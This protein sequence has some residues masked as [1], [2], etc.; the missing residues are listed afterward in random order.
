MHDEGRRCVSAGDPGPPDRDPRRGVGRAHPQAGPLRGGVS[1]RAVRRPSARPQGRS[2]PAQPD[3]RPRSSPRS[4]SAYLEAGADITTTNTFTATSIGQADYGLEGYAAEMSFEGA[5]LARPACDEATALDPS[6]PRFVAGSIGPLN[7]SLSVSPKVDDPAFR[8][9][10]FDQVV[11]TYAEQIR[12]LVDGGADI[13]LIETIF[14]TLNA[15]AAIAAALDVA[16]DVPRWLSFTA[17]DRSGRNLSGQTVEAFWTS[18]EH[19]S[20]LVVGINCA[21][22]AGQ[23]RPFLEEIANAAP[24]YVACYPNAGLP[25]A[26]GEHDE[27]P[28]VTGTLLRGFA[29]DGLVNIVGGCCGTTPEHIAKIARLV[30]GVPPRAVPV[31]PSRPRTSGLEPF[32]IGPDTGFVMVGERTNVTGSARFRRLIEAGRLPGRRRRRA[33]AGAGRREP[34]RR[35]HGRRP[36][37]RRGGDDAVPQPPRRR[38]RDRPHPGDGRQ[39]ALERARGR[40]EVPPGQGHRQLDLAEGGRGGVPGAGPADPPLRRRG[41]RD[42]VRRAG[43]GRD[44]RAEGRDLRAARSTS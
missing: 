44:R 26:F 6:R 3:A 28:D 5:R 43:A 14:D 19:A 27:T 18:V 1:R 7:V 2:R 37:R 24:V 35:E 8:S 39:L 15:K 41:R 40:A 29:D 9:V 32:E 12:A 13:L 34:D 11:A 42:G 38:A 17:I 10:T 33:R 21:L 20:P 16:P 22:G 31:I 4:T 30:E 36:A 23:M 25:N